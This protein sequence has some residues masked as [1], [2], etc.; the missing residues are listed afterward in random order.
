M[1]DTAT[2]TVV[3]TVPVGS[4]PFG[5]AITPDGTTA[6]VVNNGSNTVSVIDTAGT[7]TITVQA[8]GN[9]KDVLTGGPGSDLLL[10]QNG[11]GTLIGGGGVDLLC[12]GRGKSMPWLVAPA[13]TEPPGGGLPAGIALGPGSIQ[14]RFRVGPRGAPE[15]LHARASHHERLRSLRRPDQW[16]Q[17]CGSG[18]V[19]TM[20]DDVEQTALVRFDEGSSFRSADG[21]QGLVV[22]IGDH[23][24]WVT[25]GSKDHGECRVRL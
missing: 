3:A 2:N 13:G 15:T 9:G 18:G 8:G 7:T 10:G 1:I 22:E 4:F 11:K 16:P 21:N 12:G 14:V 17:Q 20:S 23:R 5:I 25:Q 19:H 6:Y 24:F